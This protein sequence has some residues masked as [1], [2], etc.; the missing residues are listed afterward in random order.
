[1]T[2]TIALAALSLVLVVLAIAEV[3]QAVGVN[4]LKLLDRLFVIATFTVAF[5]YSLAPLA[6]KIAF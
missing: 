6:A 4:A 1:M 2:W 5:I 3:R